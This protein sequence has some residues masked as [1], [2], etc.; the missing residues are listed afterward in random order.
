MIGYRGMIPGGEM[1]EMI[2]EG[3]LASMPSTLHHSGILCQRER[4]YSYEGRE[5]NQRNIKGI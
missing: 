4:D 2:I 1:I 3:A 5:S